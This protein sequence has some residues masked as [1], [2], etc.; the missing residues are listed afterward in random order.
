MS[1]RVPPD[2]EPIHALPASPEAF[3]RLSYE[4]DARNRQL[5]VWLARIARRDEAALGLLY[6]ELLGMVY[7][8]ISRI[9]RRPELAEEVTEDV[10]FQIWRQADR[11][12]SQ[13]GR[14]LGWILTI[15]RSRALDRLRGPEA[16]A[17]SAPAALAQ[18]GESRTDETPCDLLEACE[19]SGRLH[20]AL[21]AL[22]PLPRQIVT[23]A[24]LRGLTHEEI[25]E[26]LALPLG[27][28]KSHVRRALASLHRRLVHRI[29]RSRTSP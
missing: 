9:V 11:F 15:A 28:V 10:F 6:D 12:D 7:G 16:T 14:P 29:D 13:R 5:A 22:D 27:T 1:E 26:H 21:A 25:A 3:D 23:L 4:E 17:P 18:N 24:F 19:E 8:L 2:F 20:A